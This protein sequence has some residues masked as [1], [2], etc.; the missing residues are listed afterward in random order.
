MDNKRE[1][2]NQNTL[3]YFLLEIM[4]ISL[5]EILKVQ[6]C[7]FEYE[8]IKPG[9]SNRNLDIWDE[10]LSR[11]SVNSILMNDNILIF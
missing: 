5:K 4:E 1:G 6:C 11:I 10:G 3:Y 2:L 8:N 9:M 7:K